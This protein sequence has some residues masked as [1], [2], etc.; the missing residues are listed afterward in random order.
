MVNNSILRELIINNTKELCEI[1]DCTK[2]GFNELCKYYSGG[3]IYFNE[4]N[5]YDIIIACI[6]FKEN[7]LLYYSKKYLFKHLNPNILN[8]FLQVRQN[9]SKY[10]G[11]N[12]LFQEIKQFLL[13]NVVNFNPEEYINYANNEVIP[14]QEANL[15]VY[16]EPLPVIQPPRE[17]SIILYILDGNLQFISNLVKEQNSMEINRVLDTNFIDEVIKSDQ[18]ISDITRYYNLNPDK[19][20]FLVIL[21]MIN[22][23]SNI[24]KRFVE[25]IPSELIN[26]SLKKILNGL[27]IDYS[28]EI[29]GIIYLY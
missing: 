20:I 4:N 8:N 10:Y 11:F 22:N 7:R 5:I 12:A 9:M 27:N 28:L 21:S 26:S 3:K 2:D 14:Q 25:N 17:I 1:K 15:P 16:N 19:N 29:N 18:F 13:S 24:K 23:N 6:R